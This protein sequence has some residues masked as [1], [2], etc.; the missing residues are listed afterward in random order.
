M[1]K[2]KHI[3]PDVVKGQGK[4]SESSDIF[5]FGVVIGDCSHLQNIAQMCM[6]RWEI[7]PSLS[8]VTHELKGST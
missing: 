6:T 3:A 2:Y 7:R 8:F 1:R 4:Q 5:A